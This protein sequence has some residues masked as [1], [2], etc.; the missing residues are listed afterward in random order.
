MFAKLYGPDSKHPSMLGTYLAACLFYKILGSKS[1]VGATYR[2]NQV[3]QTHGHYLQQIAE[4]VAY[5]GGLKPMPSSVT[6]A[7][8][9]CPISVVVPRGYPCPNDLKPTAPRG[10]V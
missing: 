4:S 5:G 2:P 6:D 7:Q 1:P 10:L 8:E 9:M 3:S